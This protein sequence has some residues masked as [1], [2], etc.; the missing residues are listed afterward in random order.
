MNTTT[1]AS[2]RRRWWRG[3]AVTGVLALAL[4]TAAGCGTEDSDV[5]ADPS[6]SPMATSTQNPSPSQSPSQAP[7]E[8]APEEAS[9]S[10]SA[11]A[12][13]TYIR[14]AG[15]EYAGPFVADSSQ[16]DK[17][18][19]APESFKTF[20]GTVADELEATNDCKPKS[21][22]NVFDVRSDGYAS[23]GVHQC[24]GYVALWAEVDGTW[25]EIGG[26]QA[27]W[28]CSLLKRYGVPHVVVNKCAV[29]GQDELVVNH[30]K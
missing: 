16:I 10:A 22:V 1:A 14:Y 7:S 29:P 12:K 18:E 6:A 19:G 17:L 2:I 5:A 13:P 8:F 15:G 9:V 28:R 11:S 24:G 25:K 4:G 20:I 3:L 23:G 30:Q 21:G 27:A 26:T